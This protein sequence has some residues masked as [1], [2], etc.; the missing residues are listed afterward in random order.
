[1]GEGLEARANITANNVRDMQGLDG[2]NNWTK[3]HDIHVNPTGSDSE[4][5]AYT[6]FRIHTQL[7]S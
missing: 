7:R 1:M 6:E 5:I 3:R 4:V 2:E